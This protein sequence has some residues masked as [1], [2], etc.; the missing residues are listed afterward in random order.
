MEKEIKK[1]T[2]D[3]AV[4]LMNELNLR[5]QEVQ[6]KLALMSAH[7]Y[8]LSVEDELRQLKQD[9]LQFENGRTSI[10]KRETEEEKTS[11]TKET[12]KGSRHIDAETGEDQVSKLATWW[13]N[14]G[15]ASSNSKK[16]VSKTQ[17]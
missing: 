9:M 15:N 13:T 16:R 7:S 2:N 17:V 12:K 8:T 3:L 14:R 1:L 6:V 5:Q 4:A 11:C 10:I